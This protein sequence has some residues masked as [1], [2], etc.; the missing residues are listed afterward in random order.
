MHIF[1]SSSSLTSDHVR[2]YLNTRSRFRCCLVSDITRAKFW[3][4]MEVYIC[5]KYTKPGMGWWES[6]ELVKKG[7]WRLVEPVRKG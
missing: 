7:W 2:D 4:S 6:V 1:I 5:G 3:G